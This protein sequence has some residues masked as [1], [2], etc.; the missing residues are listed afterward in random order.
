MNSHMHHEQDET[1]LM[2]SLRVSS[3][4]GHRGRWC[5]AC[6]LNRRCPAVDDQGLFCRRRQ[7][8]QKPTMGMITI[9]KV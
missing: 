4:G 7:W 6:Q 3:C 1:L 5:G 8:W 9:L 2:I